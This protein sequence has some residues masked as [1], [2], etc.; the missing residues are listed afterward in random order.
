L[1]LNFLLGAPPAPPPVPVRRETYVKRFTTICHWLAKYRFDSLDLAG[2]E[3]CDIEGPIVLYAN[4]PDFWDPIVC[5]L[6]CKA[7]LP[8]HQ[9]FAPIDAEALETHWYFR[10]LG[11]F[12]RGSKFG[13]GPP[14]LP[15]NRGEH[16]PKRRATLP[17]TDT[18]GSLHRPGATTR[19]LPE[20]S[21]RPARP[22]QT[23]PCSPAR[24][25]L[26]VFGNR[27]AHR[28]SLPRGSDRNR[29]L[30]PCPTSLRSRARHAESARP[31]RPT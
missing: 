23:P 25:E 14:R 3:H 19:C 24:S 1:L 9:V 2:R 11:F 8:T 4:H 5:A 15:Y 10:G 12:R 6:I 7:L 16:P 31:E 18:R 30:E 22:R 21:L 29:G 17:N 28:L 26:P 27:K 13:S 20:R